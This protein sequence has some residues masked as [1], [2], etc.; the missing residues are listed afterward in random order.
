MDDLKSTIRQTV[1]ETLDSLN[2]TEIIYYGSVTH[3]DDPL[4]LGRVRI[5]PK[6]WVVGSYEDAYAVNEK[7]YWTPK[8]P[9]VFLPLLPIFLYQIP[10][11][12]E[13]VHVIFYNSAY[14]DRNKFYIQGGFSSINNIYNEEF[15]SSTKYTALGERNTPSENITQNGF[16]K[17]PENK[18]LYPDPNTIGLLGRYNSDVL[19]PEGGYVARVNKFGS[20]PDT[21]PTFNKRHS[22]S[23]IQNYKTR[24]VNNGKS[25]YFE[26]NE[27][28]ENLQYV[29]EYNVYGGLGSLTG[30]FSGYINV[31]KISPYN[32]IRTSTIK[33]NTFN[34]IPEDRR[35]GPIYR[36]DFTFESFEYICDGF[37]EVIELMND[38]K[39]IVNN[40]YI[41]QPFPFIF[42][43]EQSFFD[44]YNP[45]IT[46]A[47][48]NPTEENA[49]AFIKNVYLNQLTSTKGFG[50]VSE[51][52]K[53]G[54]TKQLNRTE[55]DNI[56]ELPE[57]ITYSIDVS[58]VK[59][60]LS[61]ESNPIP[62]LNKIDFQDAAW[63]G[64]TLDRDFIF[65]TILPNTNSMV[66]G[67]KLLELL[68]LIVKY[69]INHVHP[70]HGMAP[71]SKSIDGTTTS[72]LL[73]KIFDAYNSVLN[74]NLRIN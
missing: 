16:I 3:T 56:S 29:I 34:T 13:W 27:I 70:Y 74:Q 30:L 60:I 61:H 32:P 28:I 46:I 45:G 58:D 20:T 55:V 18:D 4:N 67:E 48:N 22:F 41:S 10:K 17:N 54:R 24:K 12:D 9:F 39:L 53:L 72:D 11:K 6:N 66:R 49:T 52:N 15:K 63:S 8:D 57:N 42:Q 71:D 19:L 44:K 5:T 23:M 37:R 35:L 2:L 33:E 26:N 7:D 31:Y 62:G 51:K 73:G 64:N 65:N 59:M 69:L 68:E 21:N 43:P 36:K 14:S 50:L 1:I 47:A 40:E 38:S 25:V